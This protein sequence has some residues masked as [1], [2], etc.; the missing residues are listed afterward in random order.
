MGTKCEIC[1]NYE[2]DDLFC[3]SCGSP[4]NQPKQQ[5]SPPV[6][7]HQP[8]YQNPINC[9]H[10]NNVTDGDEDFCLVCYMPIHEKEENMPQEEYNCPNCNF[11]IT[12]FSYG[13]CPACET[14]LPSTLS[15]A[16]ASDASNMS[17]QSGSSGFAAVSPQQQKIGVE[18]QPDE[19]LVLEPIPSAETA[20]PYCPRCGLKSKES[21]AL[22]CDLDGTR[23][24]QT[25]PIDQIKRPSIQIRRNVIKIGSKPIKIGRNSL[26]KYYRG[27]AVAPISGVHLEVYEKNGQYFVKDLGSTN[28]TTLN[29]RKLQANVPEQVRDGDVVILGNVRSLPLIFRL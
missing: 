8:K 26:I 5:S 12:D 7:S 18:S 13:K 2:E 6:V 22:F 1:G 21:F 3:S 23:L 19:E 27:N 9:P 28:G 29:G 25:V 20:S 4:L 24:E 11:A 15:N 14:P 10:C 16:S 17:S